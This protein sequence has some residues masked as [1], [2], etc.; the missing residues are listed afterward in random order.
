MVVL[1]AGFVMMTVNWFAISPTF[2][3]V[4]T[5]FHVSIPQLGLLVSI[6]VAG[7]GILHIPAGLL[8]TRIGLRTTLVVGL[9]L[10]GITAALSGLANSYWLLMVLRI[11]CGAGTGIYAA[12]GIAA[13]SV[14]FT[15]RFHA[16]ALGVISAT[17]GV[18]AALGLYIWSDLVTALGW[19]AALIIGGAITILVT[20][21]IGVV[22]RVPP[23]SSARLAG[24]RLTR[25]AVR[26]TLGN[27]RLWRYG[28]A[29]LGG[30]GAYFAASQLLGTY[31]HDSGRFTTSQASIAALLIA[32]TGVPGS[33]LIGWLSDRLGQRRAIILGDRTARHR[34]AGPPTRDRSMALATRDNR[35]CGLQRML[36]RVAE[37]G[38]RRRQNKPREHRDRNR[39]HAHHL[40][41]RWLR[42]PVGLRPA[43]S[44]RR[45]RRRLDHAGRRDTGVRTRRNSWPRTGTTERQRSE[46]ACRTSLNPGRVDS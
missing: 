8:A 38:Q 1:A 20:I 16:L 23:T 36:R 39:T 14:W 43:R 25:A 35:R 42:T 24:T 45:I 10:E 22:Y 5:A 12:V 15:R 18:G 44:G 4:R 7:Y 19:R 27:L 37:R 17:F 2:G 29:F 31:T 32:V 11:L 21:V 40:R 9:G 33:L 30:Y 3:Q 28:F 41:R 46:H 26:Q 13:M 34:T 6:F